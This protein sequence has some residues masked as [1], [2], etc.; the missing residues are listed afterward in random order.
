MA[1]VIKNKWNTQGSN[2]KQCIDM[3]EAVMEKTALGTEDET[4]YK[5]FMHKLKQLTHEH[6]Q[7]VAWWEKVEE[8]L[9]AKQLLYVLK[10]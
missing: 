2:V 5:E 1:S 8:K 3:I 4:T 9:T 6:E 10:G 7:K